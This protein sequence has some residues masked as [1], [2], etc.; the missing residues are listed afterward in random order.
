MESKSGTIDLNGSKLCP[1]C[2]CCSVKHAN[3]FF[4]EPVRV[5]DRNVLTVASHVSGPLREE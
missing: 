2:G 5:R 1:I 4:R 3:L